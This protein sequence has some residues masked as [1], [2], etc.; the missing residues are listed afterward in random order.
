MADPRERCPDERLFSIQ[1][2]FYVRSQVCPTRV[3]RYVLCY[4]HDVHQAMGRA[5]ALIDRTPPAP[6]DPDA[7][8]M[9][10]LRLTP[11]R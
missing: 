4:G 11:W 10:M 1:A 5:T 2:D 9:T 3:V 6:T 7:V 8:V